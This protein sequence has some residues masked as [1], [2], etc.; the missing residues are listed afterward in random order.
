MKRTVILSILGIYSIVLFCFP[1][2]HSADTVVICE[3]VLLTG[4]FVV[5][6]MPKDSNP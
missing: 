2:K 6:A 1:G 3:V 4:I 5:M